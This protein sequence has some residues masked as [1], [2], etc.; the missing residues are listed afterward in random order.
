MILETELRSPS[1]TA[2]ITDLL[3]MTGDPMQSPSNQIIREVECIQGEVEVS[4][5]IAPR[6][7]YGAVRPWMEALGG[8]RFAAVGGADG[9]EIWSDV[10]LEVSGEH[11][12]V[13]ACRLEAGHARV[14]SITYGAPEDLI[15]G[16]GTGRSC[17]SAG[18]ARAL[19]DATSAWWLGW[20]DACA[21]GD[22]HDEQV[23]RSV[24][25]LKSLQ[26][27]HTGAVAAA[28][29]TS[30][31]EV[32]G[33]SWNWDYRYSWLRDSWLT[34]RA[35]ADVGFE[36]EAEQFRRFVERA[37]AGSASEL[38][39]MYGLD[40]RHRITEDELDWL[41]GFRGAGP[42]RVGNAAHSQLQ[43][44]MYG[45]LLELSWR[46]HRR[47][48]APDEEYWRFVRGVVDVVSERWRE[49]DHGVWE[50]RGTPRHYVYSKAMCWVALDRGIRL[51]RA[52]GESRIEGWE[53]ARDDVRATV[54][55]RG[56]HPRRGCLVEV[57]DGDNVDDSALLLLAGTDFIEVGDPRFAAT[58]DAVMHDL[59]DGGLIRRFRHGDDSAG[60]GVFVACTFWLVECLVLLGRHELA[61][62][63]F[64]RGMGAAN[65]LGLLAEEVDPRT[66]EMLGNF[67]QGLSHLAH[68]SAALLLRRGGAVSPPARAAGSR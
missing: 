63:H 60:E 29:T 45:Y 34:V 65:D 42:V 5:R 13:G 46:W 3:V 31:P 48:S 41:D 50:L 18:A 17:A 57:F 10:E 24:L 55:R 67:P 28:P 62:E 58:V 39:L 61:A 11:D 1:G 43:L 20:C 7:D 68:V 49:P 19:V 53:R 44:D 54:D 38:Q 22:G 2:R 30:L 56:T 66:G 8:G 32:P 15:D 16:P 51:A 37:S 23:W 47:G 64:R 33:G 40:G 26:N 6:F 35:L 14:L 4:L 12:L 25:V 59:D 36:R 52:L 9:L 27:G 21:V